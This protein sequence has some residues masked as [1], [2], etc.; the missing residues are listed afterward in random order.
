MTLDRENSR[1]LRE[2]LQEEKGL[3]NQEKRAKKADLFAVFSAILGL[4]PGPQKSSQA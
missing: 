1:M 2:A 3:L 4:R